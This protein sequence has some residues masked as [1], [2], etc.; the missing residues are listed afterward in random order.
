[1]EK[2]CGACF[3]LSKSVY[4]ITPLARVSSL[5]GVEAKS[6]RNVRYGSKAEV[7][8]IHSNVCF[9]LE[10]RH[11]E[12]KEKCPLRAKSGHCLMARRPRIQKRQWTLIHDNSKRRQNR[13]SVKEFCRVTDSAFLTSLK[14]Q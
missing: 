13:I 4:S 7:K 2:F 8:A 3:V 14:E 10:S 5:G 9:T 6:R 1:M 12:S 11:L